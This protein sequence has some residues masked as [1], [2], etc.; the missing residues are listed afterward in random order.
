M[1]TKQDMA[2]ELA[3]IQSQNG[4]GRLEVDTPSGKLEAHL[5]T[6]DA[7]GCA[8]ESFSYQTDK[9]A[10]STVKD[11]K[12]LSDSLTAKL[13]YLMEPISAVE[14]DA[15]SCTVQCRSNPPQQGED[16]RSYY[17]LL[18]RKGGDIVLCRYLKQSGQPRQVIPSQVTREVL[19][20]LGEDFVTAVA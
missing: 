3:R 7:I 6:V 8:F 12:K 16:G 20:R 19:S 5:V 10:N 4:L 15:D 2:R 18:V 1:T 17:E 13:N 9:L 11:L 14:L